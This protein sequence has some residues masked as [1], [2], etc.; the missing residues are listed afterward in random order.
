MS[1]TQITIIIL[2]I[3][4]ALFAKNVYSNYLEQQKNKYTNDMTIKVLNILQQKVTTSQK[5][6][7]RN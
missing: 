5:E 6:K 3:I 2:F 1:G 7:Q 4:G